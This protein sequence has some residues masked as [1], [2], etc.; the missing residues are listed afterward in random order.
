MTIVHYVISGRSALSA[1]PQ[2]KRDGDILET[3]KSTSEQARQH[4]FALEEVRLFSFLATV[5]HQT[6]HPT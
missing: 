2:D 6:A 4:S 3:S 1:S 5:R